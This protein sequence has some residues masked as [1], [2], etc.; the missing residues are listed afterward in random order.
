L[1]ARDLIILVRHA[2]RDLSD[3]EMDNG[4]SAKGR[5]QARALSKCLKDRLEKKEKVVLFSS[6]K[7]RCLETLEPLAR[8]FGRRL[9]YSDLLLEQQAGE[10]QTAFQARVTRGVREISTLQKSGA[11]ILV[12]SHGDWLPIALRR[13]CGVK[14]EL[15]KAGFA[16]IENGQLVRLLQS[17]DF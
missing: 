5:K 7:R 2:H 12:C 15:K 11:V 13:L 1:A 8:Y 10:T 6:P 4:L 16:E 14:V 9:Q 3:P 17:S